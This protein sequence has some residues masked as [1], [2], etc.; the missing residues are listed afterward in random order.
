MRAQERSSGA[1]VDIIS[2]SGTIIVSVD[3]QAG[4]DKAMQIHSGIL[5]QL[6]LSKAAKVDC[7]VGVH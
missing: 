6:K 3:T 5:M 7:Y 4:A 2:H 1:N